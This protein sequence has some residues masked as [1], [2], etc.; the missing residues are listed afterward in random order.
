M[1]MLADAFGLRQRAGWRKILEAA[2]MT[3]PFLGIREALGS[4][5]EATGVRLKPALRN[6]VVQHWNLAANATKLYEDVL[7]ALD[8]LRPRLRTALLSN[9]Q[10]FD[11]QFIQTSGLAARLDVQCLSCHV[12]RLKPD[13]SFF[14]EAVKSLGIGVGEALMVGDSITDDVEG[15]LGAGLQAVHLARQGR[16]GGVQ[17]SAGFVTSLTGLVSLVS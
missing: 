10:S 1:E 16:P 2:M 7:P 17:G 11:I 13:P 8:A 3:R 5:E 14:Q 4:L 12:G 6:A 15:A 9:T